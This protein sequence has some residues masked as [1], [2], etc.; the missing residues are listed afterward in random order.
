MTPAR[1]PADQAA[2]WLSHDPAR[3][4]ARFFRSPWC[5]EG[6]ACAVA[7]PLPSRQI[8]SWPWASCGAPPLPLRPRC[9]PPHLLHNFPSGCRRRG[10]PRRSGPRLVHLGCHLSSPRLN[11]LQRPLILSPQVLIR[12]ETRLKTTDEREIFFV[13]VQLDELDML[14]PAC[15][16]RPFVM[17]FPHH[18]SLFSRSQRS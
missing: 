11:S 4:R 12:R 13:F 17:L 6:D 10:N 5:A 9:P 18:C 1:S 2:V 7:C 16:Q 14:F 15:E 3:T 8:P